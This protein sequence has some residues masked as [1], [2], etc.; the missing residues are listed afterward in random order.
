MSDTYLLYR[1]RLVSRRKKLGISLQSLADK[2]GVSKSLISKIEL[3]Q[4]QPSI[5]TA[6]HIAQG[7][8]CSL[9]EMF[10]PE[11]SDQIILQPT[12]Q[13]FIL[14]KGSHTKKIVSPSIRGACIEIFHEHLKENETIDRKNYF[15]AEVFILALDNELSIHAKDTEYTLKKGDCLYLERNIAHTISNQGK[16]PINFISTVHHHNH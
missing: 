16:Y 6:S 2:S 5:Q 7:L 11:K 13:Q 3:A 14:S 9:S 8:G 12:E 10:Q 1:K 15:N 4:V